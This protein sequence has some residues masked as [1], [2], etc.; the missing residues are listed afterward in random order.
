MEDN[1]KEERSGGMGTNFSKCEVM[2]LE[3]LFFLSKKVKATKGPICNYAFL[4]A[5]KEGEGKQALDRPKS[6]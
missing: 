4:R 3:G 6:P 5:S 1:Q 2:R